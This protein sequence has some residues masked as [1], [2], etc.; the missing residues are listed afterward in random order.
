M[1]LLISTVLEVFPFPP[2]PHPL[3]AITL[4]QF[5]QPFWCFQ[6]LDLLDFLCFHL[7]WHR[8]FCILLALILEHA[9]MFT[10]LYSAV[11]TKVIMH[12]FSVTYCLY[13]QAF[14]LCCVT[15]CFRWF[16]LSIT[17]LEMLVLCFLFCF[18]WQLILGSRHA[19][20]VISYFACF[21][22]CNIHLIQ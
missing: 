7:A 14:I 20:S 9:L 19:M 10:V 6:H 12:P 5:P 17:V 11:E 8:T 15:I 18:L 1:I 16:T 3:C 13:T 4:L 2:T 21:S 22:A